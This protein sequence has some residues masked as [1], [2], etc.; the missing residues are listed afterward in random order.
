VQALLT[1]GVDVEPTPRLAVDTQ[2]VVFHAGVSRR[3]IRVLNLG[4]EEGGFTV[5]LD[6][7]Q[8]GQFSVTPTNGNLPATG[9]VPLV[10]TLQRGTLRAGSA[11]LHITGTGAAANQ[12]VV[13]VLSWNDA[14]PA[15]LAE[16][17]RVQVAA[18]RRG[19]D[20]ALEPMGTAE[21][22]RVDGFAYSLSGLP[23][24]DYEVRAIGDDNGDGV[25]DAQFESVG[26]WPVSDGPRPVTLEQDARV[27]GIDFAI[28]PRFVIT[29]DNGVGAPCTADRS[30]EDCAGIDF[31]PDPACIEGFPGGYCSRLCDDG[32]C[33]PFARCDTLTC[34][35]GEPCNVCLQK[36]VNSAQCR[37][38]YVC[39]L[40]T[41]VP[42]GFDD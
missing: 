16:L 26:A 30:D 34:G 39:V 21:A 20:G 3:D 35:N 17:E 7:A 8:A 42:P 40:Q 32:E 23:A 11:N 24:G 33:G 6:G 38:G 29:V 27:D 14:Q 5:S 19:T 28:A 13:A 9:N 4:S 12:S 36:C 18:F 31:A 10:I 1:S 15:P 37:D 22:A 41:C 2:T 25:F